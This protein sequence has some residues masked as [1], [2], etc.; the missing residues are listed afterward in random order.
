MQGGVHLLSGLIIASLSKKKEFKLGAVIG[1]ILPD[2]DI[3]LIGPFYFV[4]GASV[5]ELHRTFTHS[6]LSVIVL[7]G[8]IASLSFVP[9]IK[10][11]F[12]DFD[13]VSLGLGIAFGMLVHIILDMFYFYGIQVFWPFWD[14]V[15]GCPLISEANHIDW[16]GCPI[17]TQNNLDPAIPADL[18]KLKLLQTTDFYTDIFF[19]YIPMIVLAFKKGVHKKARMFYLVYAIIDFLVITFFIIFAFNANV[20]Y[21]QFIVYLYIP[22]ISFLLLSVL[23]P[24]FFRDV[25][26]EFTFDAKTIV[27]IVSLFIFSQFLLFI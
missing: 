23:S 27:I 11:R 18:L 5:A 16:I 22:G 24:I 2:I 6:L 12:P 8:L 4:Y 9:F 21:E 14:A 26:R 10:K 19:F 3:F 13:F 17:I 25:I 7:G 20:G 15:I 1:A